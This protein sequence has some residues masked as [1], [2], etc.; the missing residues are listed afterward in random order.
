MLQS[1]PDHPSAQL[2]IPSV[3]KP[4]LEHLFGQN[5]FPSLQNLSISGQ[6]IEPFK[7]PTF[8]IT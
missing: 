5:F 3:Q 6:K 7:L 1:I 4:L 8:S 2:Q